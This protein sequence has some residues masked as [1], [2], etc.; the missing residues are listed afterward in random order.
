[1]RTERQQ[2][3]RRDFG[4]G[5]AA[6]AFVLALVVASCVIVGYVGSPEERFDWEL[7]SIFGTAVGTT[8]LAL[9]TGWLAYST[10]KEVRAT[11]ELAELTR[12]DQVARDRP[13]VMVEGWNHEPGKVG[14]RLTV[15]LLNVGLGPAMRVRLSAEYV[16]DSTGQA[17]TIQEVI[18]TAIPANEHATAEL[19]M[20]YPAPDWG[21]LMTRQFRV[22]GTYEDRAGRAEYP[23]EQPIVELTQRTTWSR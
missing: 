7:A 21:T 6:G 9:A 3:S 19:S 11:Q 14:G 5:L 18:I 16:G 10:R 1:M 20:T 23:L 17:P 12:E 4:S 22:T 15:R 13:V 2:P 8:L